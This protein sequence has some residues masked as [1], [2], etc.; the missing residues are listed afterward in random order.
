MTTRPL[1]PKQ[2]AFIAAYVGEAKGNATAAAR[3]AGYRGNDK[4]LCEQGRQNLEH[5]GIIQALSRFREELSRLSAETGQRQLLTA[6]R[7]HEL[8]TRI[9]EGEELETTV[10]V[11]KHGEF[12]ENVAPP[13][14]RDRLKAIEVAGKQ[15]GWD[16]P[17][18]TELSGTVGVM[19][20]TAEQDE[21]LAEWLR[22]RDDPVIA[23]RI[24]EL[25]GA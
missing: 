24:A 19:A 13:R 6:A 1:T 15:L 21:A 4:V 23:A 8:L 9:A 10:T 16:A 2:Q 20:L 11:N 22:Y 7:S 18:K 17:V 12:V 3:M 5:P 14:M 25:E